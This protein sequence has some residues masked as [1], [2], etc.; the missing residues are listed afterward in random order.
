MFAIFNNN[1]SNAF[2]ALCLSTT[3]VSSVGRPFSLSFTYYKPRISFEK[4]TH[5]S[6]N[7]VVAHLEAVAQE[8]EAEAVDGGIPE[9]E[10]MEEEEEE[11]EVEMG[12]Q[13]EEEDEDVSTS[14]FSANEVEA[15]VDFL[16][17]G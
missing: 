8:T 17:L 4:T 6:N 9:V 11:A 12:G 2:F 5:P 16:L 14:F 3:A 10:E 13:S 7:G 1:I 15:K